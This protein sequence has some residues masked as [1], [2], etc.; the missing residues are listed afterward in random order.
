MA[1]PNST[2]SVLDGG[3]GGDGGDGDDG[4]PTPDAD[5]MLEGG[6]TTTSQSQS[7]N[8]TAGQPSTTMAPSSDALNSE[9]A[10]DHF[11][12]VRLSELFL[13]RPSSGVIFAWTSPQAGAM[14]T[15]ES[16]SEK[17]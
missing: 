15:S 13:A 1:P 11:R 8:T 14:E 17:N 7:T 10:H 9:T 12:E 16:S 2:A 5:L 4:P 6:I 3:D